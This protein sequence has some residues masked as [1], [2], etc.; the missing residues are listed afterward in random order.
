M[1][2]RCLGRRLEDVLKT[3]WRRFRK[4]YCK[5]VSK[6]SSRHLAE[7]FV[8]RL[9]NTSWRRLE[10]VF[11]TSWKTKKFYAEDVFKMSWR[12]LGEQEM[13]TWILPRRVCIKYLF[14]CWIKLI[15]LF[16]LIQIS[17]YTVI[18]LCVVFNEITF[19]SNCTLLFN[20]EKALRIHHH[21]IQVNE[22]DLPCIFF[23]SKAYS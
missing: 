21:C 1:S 19:F 17:T 23:P 3:S 13:F 5:H 18:L 7:V 8:R 12:R 15:I 16:L 14:C 10:E 9:T 4:M 11:K 22:W 2:W 20:D 6:T